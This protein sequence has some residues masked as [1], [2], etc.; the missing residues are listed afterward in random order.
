VIL[1]GIGDVARTRDVEGPTGGGQPR[2]PW[3]PLVD[4]V[5]QWRNLRKITIA[6]V[7]GRVDF[8][9]LALTWAC[10]LVV[11]AEE[12]TFG[13]GP[14][15]PPGACGVEVLAQPWELG[16]RRA[17]DLLLAG[18]IVNAVDAQR[19]GMVTQVHPHAQLVFRTVMLARLV[20]RLPSRPA[21]LV[22]E[23]VDQTV[24]AISRTR[25]L[26]AA[27]G[28]H[29]LNQAYWAALAE[30][31]AARPRGLPSATAGTGS[32]TA[33]M[34]PCSQAARPSRPR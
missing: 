20:G 22:K 11:A 5:Q 14:T 23:C 32:V 17:K 12:T 6:Q 15:R 1:A 8:F 16:P 26:D 21:T 10:D 3:L 13:D 33:V 34:V 19:L 9:G 25:A 28:L 30:R 29:E 31:I 27:D 24:D 2:P 7:H 4:A 18:E